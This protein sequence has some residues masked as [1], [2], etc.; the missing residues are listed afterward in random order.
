L[1]SG[2]PVPADD[3]SEVR[4]VTRSELDDVE[5]AWAHDRAAIESVLGA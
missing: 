2:E 4:W 5:M 1:V 3:V